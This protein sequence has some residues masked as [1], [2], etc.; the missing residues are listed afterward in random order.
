MSI[1]N[2]VL[3]NAINPNQTMTTNAPEARIKL[4]G[5]HMGSIFSGV[6]L[7]KKYFVDENP[8]IVDGFMLA[9]NPQEISKP[10]LTPESVEF[11]F[12]VL[13]DKQVNG[14]MACS[15]AANF[16]KNSYYIDIDFD[17]EEEEMEKIYYDIYGSATSP[18]ICDMPP[19]TVDDLRAL[20]VGD[21]N[22]ECED[23][24]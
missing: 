5:F 24:E 14:K 2:N 22:D 15:C 11:F 6:Q 1:T 13:T 19:Q 16:N 17:C 20:Q 7:K 21:I 9:A 4:T 18:E 10:H 8:Q 3:T 23:I 12:D